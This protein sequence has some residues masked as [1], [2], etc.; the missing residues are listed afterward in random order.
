MYGN[1]ANFALE[2]KVGLR[3]DL[4]PLVLCQNRKS[5]IGEGPA[6]LGKRLGFSDSCDLNQAM[7]SSGN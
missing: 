4:I 2:T 3:Y 5:R 6:S 1:A 7:N